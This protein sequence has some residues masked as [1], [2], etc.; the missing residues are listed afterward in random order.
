MGLRSTSRSPGSF[1]RNSVLLVGIELASKVFGLVFFIVMARYLG[2]GELGGYA[3]AMGVANFFVIAP[4][5]GFEKMAQR[6]IGR[7]GHLPRSTFLELTAVKAGISIP[8]MA[9][10]ALS[11]WMFSPGQAWTGLVVGA[12]VFAYAYLE[13]LNAIFRGLQRAEYEVASRSLFS[14]LNLLIGVAILQQGGKVPAVALGQTACVA[15]AVAMSFHFL[16]PFVEKSRPDYR[17]SRL[18]EHVRKAAPLGGV[19][20]AIYFSNQMGILA[21]GTLAGDREAGYFAAAMRIFDNLTL[22]AAAVM[23]AFLPRASE[24]HQESREGFSRAA[25]FVM[26]QAVLLAMPMGVALVLLAEPIVLLLY[27]TGFAPAIPCLRILGLTLIFSYWNYVADSI[28]I[29]ADR[30]GLLFRITCAAA[31]IHVASSLGLVHLHSHVGAALS[32]LAT[33]MVYAILLSA[34]LRDTV[35]LRRLGAV[36]WK[37]VA[38]SLAMGGLLYPLRH[39]SLLLVTPLGGAVYLGV[40]L[41]TGALDFREW[42]GLGLASGRKVLRK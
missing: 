11:L 39:H 24:L 4:R 21:L 40:L 14:T 26:R 13:F 8:A 36:L 27:G 5:F 35:S 1:F 38:A 37:P 12:F 15:A 28:L 34:A 3:F 16:G 29:A 6:E 10:L 42:R 41:A 23:G 7:M 33:Q 19:L 30:E 32:V 9:A 31:L 17:W 2:A 20:V 22:L 25:E 18:V